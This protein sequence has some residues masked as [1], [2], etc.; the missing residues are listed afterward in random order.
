MEDSSTRAQL[1]TSYAVSEGL[2]AAAPWGLA[3]TGAVCAA[4][5]WHA[6]FSRS[7]GVS[8]KCA[9]A[10]MPPLFVF[11][12]A[13]EH[14]VNRLMSQREAVVEKSERKSGGFTGHIKAVN[15]L[16]DHTLVCFG[17]AVA[18]MYGAILHYELKRPRPSTW[19]LS[20][21]IIHTRVYG[22]A[23]AIASL[24]TIFGAKDFLGKMG[25]P[26]DLDDE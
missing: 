8:G 22:Q 19:R 13:G 14:A 1:A 3:S 26:W 16:M 21:S 7:L 6:G 17:L 2:S 18:P 23:A 5:K 9:L 15:F 20:H 10:I 25:A 4:H 24:V 11:S 12:L